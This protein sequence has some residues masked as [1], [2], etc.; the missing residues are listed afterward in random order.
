MDLFVSDFRST[1]TTY[2]LH[3]LHERS[4]LIIIPFSSVSKPLKSWAL[5]NQRLLLYLWLGFRQSGNLRCILDSNST[6]MKVLTQGF[7]QCTTKV[8]LL[9]R[10]GSHLNYH[11]QSMVS[12]VLIQLDVDYQH[13]IFFTRQPTKRNRRMLQTNVSGFF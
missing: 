4:V 3:Y 7:I 12:N 8:T 6:G 1:S 11:L 10:Q 2:H 13:I 9:H 5:F